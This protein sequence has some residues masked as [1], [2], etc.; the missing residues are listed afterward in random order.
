MTYVISVVQYVRVT[1][2][3]EATGVAAHVRDV[4]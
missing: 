2:L 3:S 4:D 1:C